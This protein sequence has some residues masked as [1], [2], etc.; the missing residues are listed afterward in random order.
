MHFQRLFG[1]I[2]ILKLL[3]VE[4]VPV[5]V[6]VSPCPMNFHYEFDGKEWFGIVKIYP[7]IYNRFRSDRITLNLSLVTSRPIPNLQNLNLL[8]LRKS[9]QDTYK[10]VVERQPILYHVRFP[11]VDNLPELLRIQ[12]NG[13]QVCRNYKIFFIISKIELKYTFFLPMIESDEQ[14]PD[15]YDDSASFQLDLKSP[16][17]AISNSMIDVPNVIQHRLDEDNG[18]HL[19]QFENPR[20]WKNR[21]LATNTQCGTYDEELK[22]TQLIS[23]GDKI[24][25]GTWPWITAI[26]RKDAK[27]SNLVFQCTGSL[28]SNRVVLTAAHC[29]KSARNLEP[30]AARKIVLA[31][32]RHDIR[33]WTEK[34]MMITDVEKIIIH[35]DYLSKED[36]SIFD[37]DIAIL[38]TKDVISYSTMIKPICLWPTADSTPSI[39]GIN[40][41][42]VGWGQPFDNIERNVPRRLTLPVVRNNFCLPSKNS[43]KKSK[44]SKRV[45]CAGTEKRGYAPCNGDSGS[46]FA[47]HANGAWFLRG[48]VSAAL[49]DPILN[50]CD[51][52]TY[53]IFTDIIHFR[54]WIDEHI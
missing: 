25:P 43:Q 33:D 45:F 26:F 41:T 3:K 11:L 29:F 24:T 23:G 39:A 17:P 19:K 10:D 1:V 46:A 28:I 27:A 36:S 47:F 18:K 14:Q 4:C 37:A 38:I 5:P 48:I 2:L 20:G 52:N 7:Q 49:G 30:I 13:L 42:L 15:D 9:L 21:L 35:P 54:S 34:N 16:Q 32:G 22:Y 31:F 50:T 51:L 44:N 12:V 53:T 8:Q 6:P 40:G